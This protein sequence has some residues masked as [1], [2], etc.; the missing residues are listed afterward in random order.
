MDGVEIMQ[1][2]I[3]DWRADIFNYMKDLAQ[4]TS[5]Q[6]RYKALRYILIW[7]EIYYRT[8]QG[9]LLKCLGPTQALELMHDV[10]EGMCG[11]H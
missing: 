8:L 9:L 2:D 1:I 3:V 6:I 5:K 11:T 4:E 10:H 7:D